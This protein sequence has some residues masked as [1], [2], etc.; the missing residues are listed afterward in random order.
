MVLKNEVCDM[1]EER[2]WQEMK[3]MR[4]RRIDKEIMSQNLIMEELLLF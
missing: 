2:K 1:N 3:F 4:I